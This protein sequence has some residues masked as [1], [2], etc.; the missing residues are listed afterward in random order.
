MIDLSMRANT[1]YHGDCLQVLRD[2]PATCVDL[3]YLDPPFNSDANYNLLFKHTP[4]GAPRE[5]APQAMAFEDTWKWNLEADARVKEISGAV[6]HPAHKAICGLALM[7]PQTGMLAYLVYMADRLA[8]MRRVLKNSGSI[9]LH[10]DPTA[11]AY[12]RTLMDCIFGAENFRNEIVWFYP[13][14]PGRARSDFPR[15]HD[16]I[17]RYSKSDKWT[18]NDHDIRIPILPDSVERYKTARTLGGRQYV[19]GEAAT[20]GK[21]PETVWRLPA[22]KGN[23]GESTGYP[24]QKPLKL[25]ERIVRASSNRGDLTL[26]PFCGCGTTVEAA[27]KL[28]R[29]FIGIDISPFAITRVCKDRLKKAEGLEI[30]G[31]PTDL[32]SAQQLWEKSA[33]AFERW[34]AT[35]IPGIAP[36][37]V[38]SGDG[39]VDGRGIINNPPDNEKGLCVVQIKGGKTVTADNLRAFL[40]QITGG[41]ASMGIFITMKKQRITSTMREVMVKAGAFKRKDEVTAYPRMQFWS[42]EEYFAGEN[43]PVMPG[44]KDPYT[45]KPTQDSFL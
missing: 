19:G 14:T 16:T 38:Q 24:T 17:F 43:F 40:S 35:L 30:R 2:W 29:K 39:G 7:L 44:M 6:K 1:L 9:Y 45:G 3:I 42:V 41:A 36:N 5:D 8:E 25:L 27:Y 13:D 28:G 12:L 31:I 18:F 21:I 32:E 23:S 11:S 15:K 37:D 20:K 33:F 4:K 10:C 34:A 22:V 26:D